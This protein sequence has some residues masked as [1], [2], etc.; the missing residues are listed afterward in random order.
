LKCGIVSALATLTRRRHFLH[1]ALVI[2]AIV[3]AGL[4]AAAVIGL[5]TQGATA[6][7]GDQTTR[8]LR[9]CQAD[10]PG[11][12]TLLKFCATWISAWS[13]VPAGVFARSARPV[14]E[15]R[16]AQVLNAG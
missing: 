4:V 10:L 16:G 6:G 12:D 8:S 5:V 11:L 13:G 7:A 2:A 1:R 9:E 3:L 15:R 14:N